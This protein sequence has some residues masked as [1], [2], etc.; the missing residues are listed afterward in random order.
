[1]TGNYFNEGDWWLFSPELRGSLGE[2][3][4]GGFLVWKL[5]LLV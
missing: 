2:E 3:G 4:F 1:M 5:S